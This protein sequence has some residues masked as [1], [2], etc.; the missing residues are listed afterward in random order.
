MNHDKYVWSYTIT[1]LQR[2]LTRLLLVAFVPVSDQNSKP[3]FYP[4]PLIPQRIQHIGR[5]GLR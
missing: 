3:Y 5:Q 4:R 1:L 2:A